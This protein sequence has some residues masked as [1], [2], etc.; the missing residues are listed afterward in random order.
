VYRRARRA[1]R[2]GESRLAGAR[3]RGFARRGAWVSIVVATASDGPT[4]ESMAKKCPKC[5]HLNARR[6][7][8]RAAKGWMQHLLLSPY[9]CRDCG[10]RFWVLSRNTYTFGL[11][12]CIAVLAGALAWNAR[13]IADSVSADPEVAAPPGDGFAATAKLAET[14]DAAAE[15]ELAVRYAHGYGVAKNEPEAL[16]WLERAANHGDV[17]AQYELG[18]A[19]REGRGVVQNYERA[20]AWITRA[21]TSGHARAQLAL[22]LMYRGGIGVPTDN[23][24]AYVWLNLAAARGV[25]TAAAYRDG[26]LGRLSPAEVAQAQD[27]ARR[28]SE[29]QA[30]APPA[31]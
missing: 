16:V 12:V 21:A 7:S 29:A 2:I 8:T 13:T 22:G 11:V 19:L 17:T 24:K 26:M 31:K 18:I 1:A 4:K 3:S 15:H 9:R 25:E 30:K 20:A 28:M 10:E 14:G 23:M 27:E 6:S 5:G